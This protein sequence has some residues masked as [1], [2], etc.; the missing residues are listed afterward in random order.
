MDSL[1]S[2]KHKN[3][4]EIGGSLGALLYGLTK[5]MRPEVVLEFGTFKGFSAMCFAKAIKEDVILGRLPSSSR[6]LTYDIKDHEK[7]SGFSNNDFIQFGIRD[8]TN[9]D[10]VKNLYL[11]NK[12]KC[13]IIFL[14]LSTLTRE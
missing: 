4:W 9:R 14:I 7:R 5:T 12:E 11:E 1:F 13:R 6:V 10:F 3:N 2:S 8:S